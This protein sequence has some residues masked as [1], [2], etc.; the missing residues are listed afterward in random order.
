MVVGGVPNRDNLHCQ[1]IA[2]FAAI[3][4]FWMFFVQL[5]IALF[6]DQLT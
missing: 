5:R 2:N 3:R 6:L 1:H 4:N